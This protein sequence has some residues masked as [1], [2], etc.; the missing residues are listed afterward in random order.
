MLRLELRGT[1]DEAAQAAFPV[2][3]GEHRAPAAPETS[4]S[5]AIL[6]DRLTVESGRLSLWNAAELVFRCPVSALLSI[7]FEVFDDA[8]PAP[9]S[10]LSHRR[11]HTAHPAHSV[12]THPDGPRRDAHD[13]ASA[14]TRWTLADDRRL[15]E[16]HAAGVPVDTLARTLGRRKGAVRAR[17]FKLRHA[18]PGP[19]SAADRARDAPSEDSAN[20][21]TA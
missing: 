10:G 19:D 20:G 17:L 15:L 14:N 6:A 16:L 8:R 21:P 18:E 7:A 3:G 12:A 2:H 11:P 4:Q 9:S 13:L 1:A 5:F